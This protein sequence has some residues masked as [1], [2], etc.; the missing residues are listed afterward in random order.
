MASQSGLKVHCTTVPT[1]AANHIDIHDADN[2]QYH[3]GSSRLVALGTAPYD[4]PTKK[5]VNSNTNV[6][7]LTVAGTIAAADVRR[8]VSV[9]SGTN[10]LLKGG[11]FITAVS[12]LNVTISQPACTTVAPTATNPGINCSPATALSVRVEHTNNRW[13][14]NATCTTGAQTITTTAPGFA[15]TDLGKSVSGGP[16]N[17]GTYIDVAPAPAALSAHIS[18]LPAHNCTTNNNGDTTANPD[19]APITGADK[20]EIGAG[21]YATTGPNTGDPVW[22]DKDPM[23][24]E[25]SNTTGG[26]LGFACPTTSKLAMTALS[27]ADTGGFVAT[28]VGLATSVRKTASGVTTATAGKVVSVD[29]TGNTALN[30]S[31]GQCPSLGA[32]NALN[33]QAAVIGLP[34]GNA[35]ANNDAVMTL[36]AELNLSPSLVAT[37]D[38]CD[39]GTIEGFMVVGGWVNPGALYAGNTSTPPATVAQILFPTSVISFNGFIVPRAGGDSGGNPDANPHYDFS[40][41]LLPTS[42]AE[43]IDHN[44]T[45]SG[46]TATLDDHPINATGLAFAI[47]P[48]TMS[49]APFLPTGS[50]NI[51][52]PSVRTLN[53][54]TGPF[55]ITVRLINNT[56][57]VT[58]A[59]DVSTCTVVFNTTDSGFT[60]GDG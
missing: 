33:T 37:G 32:V 46:A 12:G 25:L 57:P 44:E 10:H 20:I 39:L 21:Q 51:G 34:D 27:K 5:G 6:I 23:T 40:F 2:A 26:G 43:C 52:D 36:G 13:L 60:C 53:S 19:V 18:A 11:A 7:H 48:T 50:G 45:T 9:V 4:T 14:I 28:D 8:P 41:P 16:F 31:A 22:N 30:L 55:D 1:D 49:K 56:G 59:T 35:P 17:P 58:L 24:L 47:N 38:D 29:L 15:P 42:L 3:H 54:L